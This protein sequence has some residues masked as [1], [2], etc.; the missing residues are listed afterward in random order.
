VGLDVETIKRG[1]QKLRDGQY[2]RVL[3][4]QVEV[5]D[6]DSLRR[7]FGLLGVKDEIQGAD[8]ASQTRK[9]DAR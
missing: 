9:N 4:E 7:L 8:I 2:L 1:V 3:D 5:P 6:V